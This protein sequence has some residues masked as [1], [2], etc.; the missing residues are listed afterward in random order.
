M[1]W[2]GYVAHVGRGEAYTGY[3]GGY[4]MERDHLRDPD[5]DRR[6]IIIWHFI[7]WEYGLD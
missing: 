2:A 3:W 6:I 5:V 1:R 4:L 7:K